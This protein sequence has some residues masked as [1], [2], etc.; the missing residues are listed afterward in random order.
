MLL[1]LVR[2]VNVLHHPVPAAVNDTDNY[3]N[4]CIDIGVKWTPGTCL[5]LDECTT[6]ADIII[7]IMYIY[8]AL[9]NALSAHIIP[10]SYT[11]LTL[12]TMAVV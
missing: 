2:V 12:P 9:I 7:I 10:V 8:H 6:L 11:H 3:D 1:F 5:D 4:E